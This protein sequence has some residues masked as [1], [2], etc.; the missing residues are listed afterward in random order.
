MEKRTLCPRKEAGLGSGKGLEYC[1]AAHAE[2]NA[3][4]QAA[5][6]GIKI[7]NCSMFVVGGVPCKSCAV[8]IINSGIRIVYFWS[9]DNTY[10]GIAEEIFRESG[11]ALHR[12][13]F[14][15]NKNLFYVPMYDT[16]MNND[17]PLAEKITSYVQM[18]EL[19]LKRSKCLSR[20]VGSVIVND[21]C[22]VSTGFNGPARGASHCDVRTYGV[23]KKIVEE[24]DKKPCGWCNGTGYYLGDG[25]EII[26]GIREE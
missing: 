6:L 24:A 12:L 1:V 26:I 4:S 13:K 9:D 22:I 21:D 3:I 18:C 20:K 2:Q 15:D 8:S 25:N 23:P 16:L 7:K 19:V 10:D 11:V 5:R 14:D 17:V